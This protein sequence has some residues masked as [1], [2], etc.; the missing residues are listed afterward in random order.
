MIIID[1]GNGNL[2]TDSGLARSVD[3]F[4]KKESSDISIFKEFMGN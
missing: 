4:L 3:T 2:I 1:H